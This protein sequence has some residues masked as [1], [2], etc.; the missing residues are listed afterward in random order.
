VIG[1]TAVDAVVAL[2]DTAGRDISATRAINR[3]KTALSRI[4]SDRVRT[5]LDWFD[6]CG[7][8]DRHRLHQ[9]SSRIP[10]AIL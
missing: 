10:A 6:S 1:Q 5:I 8:G 9:L 3:L 2:A 4:D 7:D